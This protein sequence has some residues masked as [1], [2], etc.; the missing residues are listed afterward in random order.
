VDKNRNFLG[1]YSG[2][3]DTRVFYKQDKDKTMSDKTEKA[4]QQ[5]AGDLHFLTIIF[6]GWLAY[7]IANLFF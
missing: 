2:T 6:I 7:K 5:I 4:I 1:I 3:G